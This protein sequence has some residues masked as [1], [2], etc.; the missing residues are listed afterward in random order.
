MER[1][2]TKTT[3][4]VKKFQTEK[5]SARYGKARCDHPLSL[6][7]FC[8]CGD[9]RRAGD[10]SVIITDAINALVHT[11]DAA[12]GRPAMLAAT[13]AGLYRTMDPLKGWQRL[14]FDSSFDPRSTCIAT[15]PQN[16]ELIWVGTAASGVLV[17]RD[18]GQTWRQSSGVP[19]EAPVNTVV[20]DPKRP[21]RVYVGTKQAFYAITR[22]RRNLESSRR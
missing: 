11:V 9:R 10:A 15:S 5:S 20:Q 14:P 21:E 6:R 22:R 7:S 2:G 19:T 16:P 1:A 12:T 8:N 3:L 17:S 13:N 4:A 18:G